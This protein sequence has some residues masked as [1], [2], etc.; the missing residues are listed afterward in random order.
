MST[1]DLHESELATGERFDFG[2]NWQRFIEKLSERRIQD[3]TAALLDRLRLEH[4]I[5]RSF[6]DVG[7]GSGLSSL[8]AFRSGARVHSFDYDPG[9]V[10]CTGELRRRYAGDS[11]RW[12]VERGS[13]LSESYM[14]GLG[15]FD[16]VY[17]WG[18]LHHT[19]SMW[20]GLRL[21]AARV[22]EDGLLFVALY[23][24][25]G[26]ISRY[27]H[28]VKR[29]SNASRA[30]RALMLALHAPYFVAARLLGNVS[31]V[32]QRR[33]RR[34]RGMEFWIDVA[35]WLG[36]LPFEV[37]TPDA[38]VRFVSNLGFSTVAVHT[39]GRR[40]G[41]NEYVFVRRKSPAG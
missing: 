26:R 1:R 38:V 25:Q 40:Q 36:G 8:A 23:N 41:C 2:S 14:R 24:D 16:V 15:T 7:S 30:G 13:A 35:D 22:A 28:A 19:G 21:A 31:R 11:T 10:A 3:S 37:A 33:P 29:L 34:T 18:V 20:Q 27:W 12:T 4:L 5:G 17:S 32:L 6:L 9:C 39:V